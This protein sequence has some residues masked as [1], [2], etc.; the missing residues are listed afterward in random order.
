MTTPDVTYR[1]RRITSTND[2]VDIANDAES[3]MFSPETMRYWRSRVLSH[4]RA[5]DNH[6]CKPGHRYAFITS[7]PDY[8]EVRRYWP[9]LA[10]DALQPGYAGIRPKLTGPGE[11][12][13]D[14]MIQGP[15]EHGVPGLVNLFGIESPGLTSCLAL[16]A[17]VARCLDP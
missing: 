9:G 10:D 4:M 16:G 5:I 17:E 6:E 13:A 14:F 15:R 11:A 8:D 3:H 2:I 1:S 12:A 7:E